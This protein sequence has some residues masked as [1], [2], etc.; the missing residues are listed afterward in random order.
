M[1]I[2]YKYIR[3]KEGPMSC[4]YIQ[5]NEYNNYQELIDISKNYLKKNDT[6]AYFGSNNSIYIMDEY[7]NGVPTC[8]INAWTEGNGNKY[9]S[10]YRIHNARIPNK[11]IIEKRCLLDPEY[12]SL[13]IEK[14]IN[15][16]ILNW[17]EDNYFIEKKLSNHILYNK[18][19]KAYCKISL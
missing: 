16:D 17:I 13:N 7:T 19:P 14:M 10:Y 1:L 2:D 5:G 8:L 9:L 3:A 4:I 15:K 12:R 11:I 6:V 18:K